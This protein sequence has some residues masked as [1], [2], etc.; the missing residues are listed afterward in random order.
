[1]ADEQNDVEQVQDSEEESSIKSAEVHIAAT[2]ES[3]Q[4]EASI[5]VEPLELPLRLLVLGDF[6]PNADPPEDWASTPPPISVDASRVQEVMEQLNPSLRLTVPS[7]LSLDTIFP[8]SLAMLNNC[9]RQPELI[10]ELKTLAIGCWT[11]RFVSIAR[12]GG[13]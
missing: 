2:T 5:D 7:P 1:M 9:L 12:D 13:N 3:V 11:S 8:P 4:A 6:T 10:G